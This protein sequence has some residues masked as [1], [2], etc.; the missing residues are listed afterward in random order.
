MLIITPGF[1]SDCIETL[2]EIEGENREYFM[3]SGGV[4]FN[5]IHPFN[6]DP[7]FIHLLKDLIDQ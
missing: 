3:E 2:E 7:E 1:V 5:Y 6:D 4:E